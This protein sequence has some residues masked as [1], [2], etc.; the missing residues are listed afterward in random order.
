LGYSSEVDKREMGQGTHW[1][2]ADV[3]GMISTTE[4]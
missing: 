2:I 3:E 4:P 1:I